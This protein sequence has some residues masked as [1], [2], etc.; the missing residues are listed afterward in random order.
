[1][2]VVATT[3]ADGGTDAGSMH[4]L[5]ERDHV[6]LWQYINPP[7]DMVARGDERDSLT[8]VDEK[9]EKDW[10]ASHPTVRTLARWSRANILGDTT[11]LC[12]E[13]GRSRLPWIQVKIPDDGAD[14]EARM[15]RRERFHLSVSSVSCVR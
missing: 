14:R 7:G 8:A 11:S 3:R 6:L 9:E 15:P 1:L 2:G 12:G 13:R 10:E 4:P 5:R